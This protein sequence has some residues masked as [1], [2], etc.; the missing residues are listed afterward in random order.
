MPNEPKMRLFKREIAHRVSPLGVSNRCICQVCPL[1]VS[2][3][4]VHRALIHQ[5]HPL[6][7]KFAVNMSTFL[8]QT[9]IC[10]ICWNGV[11]IMQKHPDWPYKSPGIHFMRVLCEV[12]DHPRSW[13]YPQFYHIWLSSGI[14]VALASLEKIGRIIY[15]FLSVVLILNIIHMSIQ[16]SHKPSSIGTN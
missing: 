8:V 16:N 4:C 10:I 11:Q 2:I 9:T 12:D 15:Q 7:E 13:N 14:R 6:V 1:G 3:R 5:V